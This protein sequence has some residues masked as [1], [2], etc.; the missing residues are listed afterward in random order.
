MCQITTNV[1]ISKEQ[2]MLP[3]FLPLSSSPTS[4]SSMTNCVVEC[5]ELHRSRSSMEARFRDLCVVLHRVAARSREATRPHLQLTE[6]ARAASYE[7]ISSCTAQGR[8]SGCVWP[9][10]SLFVGYSLES[11][12]QYLAGPS[13][14][15]CARA[16]DQ[17]ARQ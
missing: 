15:H 13:L 10:D 4:S 8:S 12:G 2:S 6:Y 17:P 7:L 3:R 11:A 14:Y 5:F 16:R 1:S 9:C